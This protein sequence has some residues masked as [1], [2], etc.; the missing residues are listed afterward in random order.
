M[1]DLSDIDPQPNS[2]R[3]AAD[4]HNREKEANSINTETPS[5]I[6]KKS[7]T[8]TSAESRGVFHRSK[9]VYANESLKRRFIKERQDYINSTDN[10][11]TASSNYID[12]LIEAGAEI[13]QILASAQHIHDSLTAEGATRETIEKRLGE[14]LDL[15]K[16]KI[17]TL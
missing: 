2:N 16:R 8:S 6:Y 10:K 9:L 3:K 11:D 14:E 17:R 1:T 4:Q 7:Q 12:R 15:Q 5:Q 13:R